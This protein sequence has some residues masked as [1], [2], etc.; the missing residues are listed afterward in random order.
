MGNARQNAD[1]LPLAGFN[2]LLVEDDLHTKELLADILNVQGGARVSTVETAREA[3]ELLIQ[4]KPDLLISNIVLP[5]EDGYA[6]IQ[7]IRSLKPEHGGQIPAIAVTASA[8]EE[9]RIRLVEAGFQAYFFKPFETEE[10]IL[11][12][13][14]LTQ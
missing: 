4:L 7:Q 3:L 1:D 6:L 11:K 12:I 10:L 13:I 14:E 9:N 8:S 5:D 2:I